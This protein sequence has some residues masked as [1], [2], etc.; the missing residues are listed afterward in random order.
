MSN[1]SRVR[2]LGPLAPYAQGFAAELERLGYSGGSAEHQLRLLA[3]LSRWLGEQDLDGPVGLE[4]IATFVDTR[5]EGGRRL[6]RS[7]AG[8]SL[9]IG[10]L[11]QLGMI[12][13]MEPGPASP[14]EELLERYRSYLMGERGLASSTV[15]TYI[16]AV[17]PLLQS[18]SAG[19]AG[20]LDLATLSAVAP[21]QHP[22]RSHSKPS[23]EATAD[24]LPRRL[25]APTERSG[26]A[27]SISDGALIAPRA[28]CDAI[29]ATVLMSETTAG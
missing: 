16:S 9:L 22:P 17:R 11:S 29:A 19:A 26:L 8:V 21:Q 24:H 10:Y 20:A 5:R 28:H 18:R 6:Y 27:G 2:V 7:M 1:W 25:P 15:R 12:R 14:V 23:D 13:E 3:H 4:E